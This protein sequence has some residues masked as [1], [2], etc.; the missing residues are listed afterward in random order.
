MYIY[1]C[2]YIYTSICTSIYIFVFLVSSFSSRFLDD[3]SWNLPLGHTSFLNFQKN[4][5]LQILGLR[6]VQGLVTFTTDFKKC[7]FSKVASFNK[8]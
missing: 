6:R 8:H 3:W 1:I 4:S 5:S 2:I 7:V